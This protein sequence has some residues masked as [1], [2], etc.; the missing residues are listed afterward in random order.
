[1]GVDR[2]RGAIFLVV[3]RRV[4]LGIFKL[5]KFNIVNAGEITVG[6][7]SS[8]SSLSASSCIYSSS[9]MCPTM[10]GVLARIAGDFF[11]NST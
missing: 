8:T 3:L 4:G 1:M 7:A 11:S 9:L 10:S 6:R 5:R 2:R